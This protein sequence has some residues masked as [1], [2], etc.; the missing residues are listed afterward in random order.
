M[1]EPLSELRQKEGWCLEEA[2]LECLLR[3]TRAHLPF[4]LLSHPFVIVQEGQTPAEG[5]E[6]SFLRLDRSAD[7]GSVSRL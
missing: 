7:A 4:S 2:N 1:G 5:R 6:H 3:M